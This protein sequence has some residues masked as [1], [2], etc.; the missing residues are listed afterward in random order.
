MKNLS[1]SDQTAEI[2]K[3]K[4]QFLSFCLV[5]LLGF[6]P[7]VEVWGESISYT[8]QPGK[9]PQDRIDDL[10][11]KTVNPGENITY[12]SPDTNVS[13]NLKV[14]YTSAVDTGTQTKWVGGNSTESIVVQSPN[15]SIADFQHWE[16]IS[17]VSKYESSHDIEITLEAVTA[18]PPTPD[19]PTPDPPAPTPGKKIRYTP[20]GNPDGYED[21]EWEEPVKIDPNAILAYYYK[22]GLLDTKA[23]F[24]RV[25]QGTACSSAFDLAKPYG[26]KN[27]F[28]FSMTYE[29]K[30]TYSMKDG[31]LILAIPGQFQKPGRQYAVMAIDKNAVV[32]LYPNT[33]KIPNIFNSKLDFEGYAFYLI[34]KD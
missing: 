2:K 28:S 4:K 12:V 18:A 25:D 34:Y 8:W 10:M 3:R 15:P 29:D 20:E 26:W 31:T 13:G 7:A 24:G 9:D 27:G 19:P 32:H 33:S 23:K 21:E 11:G 17:A 14:S 22:N 5:L 30:H 6:M 1:H 16:I